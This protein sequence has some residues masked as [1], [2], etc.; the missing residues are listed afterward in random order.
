[1]ITTRLPQPGGMGWQPGRGTKAHLF[2]AAAVLVTPPT[3]PDIR[4]WNANG[5]WGNQGNT[6]RC[7]IFAHVHCEYD[8]PV[9]HP[10]WP[11]PTE[12]LLTRLY[13]LGQDIDGTPHSDVDSGLT[14]DA[15]A[16]V[17]RN[18]GYIGEYRWGENL[19][20]VIECVRVAGP[21]ALG[22]WWPTGMDAPDS[23]GFVTY[24]GS[25]RGGHQ[26]KVDGVN[27]RQKFFRCKNS[28]GRDWGKNGF[29]YV[30]FDTMRAILED[31]GEFCIARELLNRATAP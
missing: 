19:D 14:S 25:K 16:K 29:F 3:A 13:Q 21:G 17:M 23:R 30:T 27:T 22:T 26:F 6:S 8:G 9:T 24:T 10:T 28:W 20:E 18:E 31:G 1:M 4:Y 12:A 15:A 2:R 5:W 7:T 11:K